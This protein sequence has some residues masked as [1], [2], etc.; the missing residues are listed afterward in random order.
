MRVIGNRDTDIRPDCLINKQAVQGLYEYMNNDR[1][2]LIFDCDGTIIDSYGAITDVVC[3][4]FLTHGIVCDSGEVRK[5]ALF[6]NVTY[7]VTETAR[8]YGLDPAVLWAEYGGIKEDTDRI[9]LMPGARQLLDC[10]RFTCFMY[11]HRGPGCRDILSRLGVLDAFT[12]IVDTGYGFRRKP[13][14]QG[15]DY[16]VEKYGL[17]RRKTYYVGD[18]SVDLECGKNAGVGTVFLR[19]SGLDIDCS[20]ADYSVGCLSDIMSLPF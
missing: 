19:S 2:N 1:I 5:L 7:A 18:R 20:A 9:T 12:E 15:V 14:S 3:R 13:D 4:L 16:L 6:R 11:T 10:P 17:D 8:A